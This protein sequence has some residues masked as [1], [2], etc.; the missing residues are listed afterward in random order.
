E[1]LAN[2]KSNLEEFAKLFGGI[3]GITFTVTSEDQ[4]QG[5]L[6]IDFSDAPKLLNKVGKALVLEVF[7][8]RGILLPEMNTWEGHVEGKALVMSGPLNTVSVVNLL[9]L[10]SNSPSA[11][12]TPGSSSGELTTS[13]EARRAKASKRYFTS[14]TRVIEE[15]R[16]VKGK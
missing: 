6:Q 12:T 13:D 11:E 2:A 4:F 3:D 9:S 5:R 7:G 1:C 15:N 14:V 10:F 16:S 8:R